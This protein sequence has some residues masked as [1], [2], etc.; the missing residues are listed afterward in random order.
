M[1]KKLLA[2][3]VAVSTCCAFGCSDDDSDSCKTG[4]KRCDGNNAQICVNGNWSKGTPCA[5]GC[6]KATGVCKDD[7]KP[8]DC[9]TAGEKR[10]SGKQLQECKDGN[11]S[12]LEDCAI[13]CDEATKAC[14]DGGKCTAT[15]TSQCTGSCSADKKTGY[16]W[17]KEALKTVDCPNAD[18][19]DT[20]GYVQ[21]GETP[22]CTATSTERCNVACSADKSVGYYW[23]S[24]DKKVGERKCP[25]K[26]CIVEGTSVKCESDSEPTCTGE[27]VQTG[28]EEGACCDAA[29]YQVSC[30]NENANALICA[31]GAVKKWT[32][33]D[34]ICSVGSDNKVK[35][36]NPNGTG[37]GSGTG[38]TDNLEDCTATSN[39]KC[40][41][42]CNDD[43]SVGYY[44]N[45]NKSEVG[46]RECPNK[47]C[48]IEGTSVKCAGASTCDQKPVCNEAGNKVT[49]CSSSSGL[50]DKDCPQCYVDDD[51]FWCN[52][53]QNLPQ[54]AKG[55]TSK[56]I[57]TCLS[58]TEGVFWDNNTNA[59]KDKTCTAP[60]KCNATK[61]GYVSCK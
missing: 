48:I 53:D 35:C 36:D 7:N 27:K 6:D 55:A 58:D 4:E 17:S 29:T 51:T 16:F 25:N 12:K 33:K 10:C 32:C 34:N 45:G 28:G 1:S 5:N 60:K 44:W 61:S 2:L 38:D 54:C 52:G 26:D 49:Y 19:T 23:N 24:K 47:D 56:C 37:G 39:A 11:W 3:L 43:K 15:S 21:C 18:C 30:I 9:T 22:A 13:S 31:K 57:G 20:N 46:K 40:K 41:V 42:A 14:K 59:V 50:T 8:K